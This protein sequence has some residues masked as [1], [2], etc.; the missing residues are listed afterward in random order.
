MAGVWDAAAAAVRRTTARIVDGMPAANVVSAGRCPT[1]ITAAADGPDIAPYVRDGVAALL[2]GLRSNTSGSDAD[3]PQR[4][5]FLGAGLGVA[6]AVLA[7]CWQGDASGASAGRDA[8]A[9]PRLHMYIVD[10]AAAPL[11]LSGCLVAAT[12]GARVTVE[13]A[14]SGDGAVLD[15]HTDSITW[16]LRH[17]DAAAFV[18]ELAA[19]GPVAAAGATGAAAPP[20]IDAVFVDVY[21]AGSMPEEMLQ[22]ALVT[23]LLQCLGVGRQRGGAAGGGAVPVPQQQQ[24]LAWWT[25]ASGLMCVANVS[26]TTTSNRVACLVINCGDTGGGLHGRV[27]AALA[28]AAG[29]LSV[30]MVELE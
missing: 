27:V 22:T 6:P 23:A 18:R 2:R 15:G 13:Q 16:Q 11:H 12:T 24:Q 17:R 29:K 19:E 7:A 20:P 10:V 9:A 8:P 3:A 14:G 28:S 4:V 25:C 5:V 26:P 30:P 21:S 1:A